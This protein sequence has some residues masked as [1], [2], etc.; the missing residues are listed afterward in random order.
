MTKKSKLGNDPF[1]GMGWI[2]KTEK[3]SSEEVAAPTTEKKPVSQQASKP[4]KRQ[5]DRAAKPKNEPVAP[6]ESPDNKAL[7]K[8]VTY[9]IT[10]EHDKRL[11][12]LSVELE[13]DL[14]AL[15]REAIDELQKKYAEK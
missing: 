10:P 14:S 12:L 13:R 15:I 3:G 8:K 2:A 5:S 1:S 4:A 9:Y 11:K 7:L 6:V